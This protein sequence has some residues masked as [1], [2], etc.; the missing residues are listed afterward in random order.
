LHPH[1]QIL[2]VSDRVQLSTATPNS[3]DREK[4]ERKKRKE[5]A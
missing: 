1:V 4:K 3:V 2:S 5:E